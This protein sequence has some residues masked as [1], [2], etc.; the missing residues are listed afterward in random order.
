MPAEVDQPI[1]GQPS[2]REVRAMFDS[3]AP[4]YDLLN[5][6]LSI[7]QD[8]WW[9]SR[10]AKLALVGLNAPRVLD[11]CCGTGDLALAL[12][13]R[14]R[15]ARVTAGDFS[16][17]MLLRCRDKR[18]A[19]PPFQL[20]AL[21][22]PFRDG[23]FDVVT[24]AFGVRNYADRAR[25]FAEA[26]RVLRSGGRF[27][28]LEFSRPPDNWFGRLYG[29]YSRNV[30]PRI[31]ALVS[32]HRGAYSYLPESVAVFLRPAELSA[33]L[34]AAGF[35]VATERMFAGGTVA[36]HVAERP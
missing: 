5:H 26:R 23:A 13:R 3:I 12:K 28:V 21:R 35:R 2:A 14:D 16:F 22:L 6:V 9:R 15:N 31:G 19:T 4:R 11:L 24:V 18:G 17:E 8:R 34:T 29:W 33:E 25:G 32:R 36:L 1:P 20:D 10:A 30:L 27:V 7:E